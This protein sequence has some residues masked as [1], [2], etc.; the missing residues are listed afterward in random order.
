MLF[1]CLIIA[2]EWPGA[3]EKEGLEKVGGGS[4]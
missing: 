3:A 4:R 1:V 2:V